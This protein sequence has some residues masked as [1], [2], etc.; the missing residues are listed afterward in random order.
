MLAFHLN[1]VT[2]DV[3]GQAPKR[4][5]GVVQGH[6]TTCGGGAAV[7]PGEVDYLVVEDLEAIVLCRTKPQK[8]NETGKFDSFVLR[9]GWLPNNGKPF[10]FCWG[11]SKFQ[12]NSHMISAVVGFTPAALS[13]SESPMFVASQF[14][15][16]FRVSCFFNLQANIHRRTPRSDVIFL[17]FCAQSSA[18]NSPQAGGN[19]QGV[20][21]SVYVWRGT[22]VLTPNIWSTQLEYIAVK[23]QLLVV[24]VY[25]PDVCWFI[26]PISTPYPIGT[27]CRSCESRARIEQKIPAR[28]WVEWNNLQLYNDTVGKHY[29]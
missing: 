15:I 27:S 2:V 17:V 21:C 14:Q 8:R 25:W 11:M 1:N 22:M 12:P 18:A 29:W 9:K 16:N 10:K 4:G 5:V 7:Q 3:R 23:L 19:T 6:W 20:H 24:W 13:L 28:Q 26:G